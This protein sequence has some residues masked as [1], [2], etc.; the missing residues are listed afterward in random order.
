[1]G[2]VGPGCSR[3]EWTLTGRDGSSGSAPTKPTCQVLYFAHKTLLLF[4][5][6]AEAFMQPV[7]FQSI[8]PRQLVV[9]TYID[10]F[11]AHWDQSCVWLKPG[12]RLPP[13]VQQPL[14]PLP[15]NSRW[16]LCTRRQQRRPQITSHSLLHVWPGGNISPRTGFLWLYFRVQRLQLSL[17]LVETN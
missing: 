4:S 9:P 7:S 10:L 14:N 17:V 6:V 1:M 12:L 13:R 2:Y 11:L 16:K 3:D 8:C 5:Y 15:C